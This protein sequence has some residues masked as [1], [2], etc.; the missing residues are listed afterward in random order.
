[1]TINASCVI[2]MIGAGVG[3][4]WVWGGAGVGLGW[5]RGGAEMGLRWGWGGAVL[6]LGGS[7]VGL[8]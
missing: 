6:G 7:G 5:G 2:L 3:L 4:G 1:M 8:G